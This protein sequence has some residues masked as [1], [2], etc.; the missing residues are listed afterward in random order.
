MKKLLIL[1]SLFFVCSLTQAQEKIEI[2]AR[3]S[4]DLN[5]AEF[6]NFDV[7]LINSSGK[8]ITV[9]VV[10]HKDQK[11]L[12]KFGLGPN[13]KTIVSVE[14][15]NLLRLFNNSFKEINLKL[16]FIAK[17][18]INDSQEN[19]PYI[20]FILHNPSLNSISLV[21]PGVMNPN[22]SPLSNSG[23]ALKIGQKIF[24]KKGEKEYL[25]LTVDDNIKKGDKINVVDLIKKAIN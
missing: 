4:V 6:E 25:L 12:Q 17:K 2:G 15:S 11:Q 24:Y 9:T 1:S 10:D 3:K 21:I 14:K 20:N 7:K 16:D 5:Y 19:L 23:V 8:S 18:P 13:G 22:L